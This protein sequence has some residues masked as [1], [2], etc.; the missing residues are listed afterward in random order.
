MNDKNVSKV[1]TEYC[2][3]VCNY[4]TGYKRDYNKHLLTAKH[5]MMTND[6]KKVSKVSKEFK[7]ECGKE[8]T[9]RHSLCR[10]K[11]K[12]NF[13]I[14]ST[15]IDSNMIIDIIKENQEIKNLLIEQNNK[16]NITNQLIEKLVKII[17]HK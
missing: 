15:I 16:A 12:C 14:E 2:C 6:D 11:K 9:N 3:I 5:K 4:N 17:N 8:Y 7:C 10:H 1:S 13:K